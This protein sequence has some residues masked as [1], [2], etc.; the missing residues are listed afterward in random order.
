[1]AYTHKKTKLVT[2]RIN[3]DIYDFGEDE[4]PE[5]IGN[6]TLLLPKGKTVYVYDI[7]IYDN[8]HSGVMV[9]VFYIDGEELKTTEIDATYLSPMK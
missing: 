1:M 9:E 5:T 7:F 3:E 8:C 2:K 6:S 4:N